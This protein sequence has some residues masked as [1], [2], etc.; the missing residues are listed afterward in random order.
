MLLSFS[1]RILTLLT[2][3]LSAPS[4]GIAAA[5]TSALWG[6]QG[7]L[8]SPAGR[9]PDFSHAGYHSGENNL[10]LPPVR[11][12][13]KDF[14]AVG[15]GVTDDTKAFEEG[16]ARVNNGALLVPPGRYVISRVLRIQKSNFVLRGAGSGKTVLIF[17]NSLLDVLGRQKGTGEDDNWSWAGGF[18]WVE[19]R[20]KNDKLTSLSAPAKRG[21]SL[22]QVDSVAGLAVGQAVRL[23]MTDKD[24]SLGRHFHGELMDM[25][26]SL[27]NRELVR[28][29]AR[30]VAINGKTVTLNRPLRWDVRPE[31]KAALFSVRVSLREVGLEGFRMEFPDTPYPGHYKEVGANAIWMERAWNSW[32]RDVT[33]HNADNGILL[34]ASTFCTVT[35]VRLTASEKRGLRRDHGLHRGK[36]SGHHGLQQRAG[37]DCLFS[38][39]DIQTRFLH[40]L[41]VEN[42]TGTVFMKGRGED[43]CF[44]HH[45]FMP[46]ENLFTEIDIGQ[47]TRPWLSNGSADPESAARETFWNLKSAQPITQIGTRKGPWPLMNL[48]GVPT[49]LAASNDPRGAWIEVIPQNKL[50]P[51]NLYLAQL[52]K[53]LA[54]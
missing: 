12:S 33:I 52:E 24:G 32:V 8:W 44:D 34:E 43:I 14:G 31:W 18:L 27:K 45:T 19:G 50:K 48:I 1:P 39:F 47:G 46:Y 20:E 42:A 25:H 16:I 28:F 30:I 5:A 49:T 10:P 36:H 6:K 17:P 7:E 26:P 3:L 54:K 11:A 53:R 9:L 21:D 4:L 13:V 2:I 41:T 22:V 40:D 51:S 37:D 15:D 38:Y 23:K 35:G 29:A